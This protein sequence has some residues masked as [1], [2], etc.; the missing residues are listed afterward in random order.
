[1]TITSHYKTIE[2]STQYQLFAFGGCLFTK[3]GKFIIKNIVIK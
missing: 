2:I 1:M 3:N